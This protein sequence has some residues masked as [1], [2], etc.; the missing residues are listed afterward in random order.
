MRIWI[1]TNFQA[2][3]GTIHECI[4]ALAAVC[5]EVDTSY[6]VTEVSTD[7]IYLHYDDGTTWR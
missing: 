6:R 1:L 2:S 7:V 4:A 5:L 3:L